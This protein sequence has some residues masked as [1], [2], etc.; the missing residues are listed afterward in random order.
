MQSTVS[1]FI[2]SSLQVPSKRN[3]CPACPTNQ[4]C[5]IELTPMASRRHDVFAAYLITFRSIA[6]EP[7]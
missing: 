7:V 5:S 4:V 1:F 6:F 2:A 3:T